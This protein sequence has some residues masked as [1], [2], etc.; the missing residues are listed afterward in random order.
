M[1]QLLP[2]LALLLTTLSVH[3]A[4]S[5]YVDLVQR[6]TDLEYLATLPAPGNTCAQWSSYDR[7][8]QYDEATGKYLGWGAN[9]DGTG[10]IRLEGEQQV[11]AEMTGPGCIWRI[12]SAA[13]RAGHVRIY[14]DGAAE[15]AVDLPFSGYFDRQTEPF[16]YPSL[17][18]NTGSGQNNYVP[19]PYSKSCK[20]VADQDWGLYFQFVYQTFPAG[21]V[22]PTFKLALSAEEKAAL[23][24]AD[25]FLSNKLGTAPLVRPHVYIGPQQWTVRA[26]QT[27]RIDEIKGSG[28]I[29]DLHASLV[30]VPEA[31]VEKALREVA[32]Q[33]KWDG[34]T[35][36]SVWSPLGDFFGTGPG[37]N[38]YKSLP[39]GITDKEFYS[40]WYMP[41]SKSAAVELVNDGQTDRTVRLVVL[42][43]ALDQA[44][45][46]TLARF[47]AKWHRDIFNPEAP[48]RAPDWTMLKTEG[49]GRFVGVAL[50]VWNPRGGWWGEGDEKFFVDGEKFPST[51]GTGSEDY[52][53]YAWCNPALFANAYHNQTRNDGNNFNHAS[54]N[55]WHIADNVPFQTSFEAAIEKYQGNQRPTQYEAVAYW[56]LAPGGQDG[57]GPVPL[58]ERLDYYTQLQIKNADG[59]F[60][61]EAL[62]FLEGSA[63]AQEMDGFGQDKWSG[64]MQLWWTPGQPGGK[65]VLAIPVEKDG[66]YKLTTVLTKAID[67]GLVQL[68]LD[69]RKLGD[70][71]DLF[72]HGVIPTPILDLG[73]HDLTQGDHRL[74]VEMIGKHDA[75]QPGYMFGMDWIKLSEVR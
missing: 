53:G 6:L 31:E 8:S 70:P 32:L 67:Y 72:N 59:A 2:L 44:K 66:K 45:A 17:V 75:A 58:A 47:H 15:P 22:V 71:I 37:I 38:R 10:F 16:I 40:Y 34:E 55:R 69:D 23:Q 41:F 33:I 74:T 1:R 20:I 50:N 43:E 56:Y 26:G 21:T 11:L 48:D 57:Y 63:G 64:D 73:T 27:L 19:I 39:M 52:F 3:A 49:R 46:D 18:H 5:I 68:Y 30:D 42:N 54:V 36:P 61:A 51:I 9:G 65:I 28:A 35:E 12:W 25:D 13:P 60:E 4:T 24:K 14:L 7:A 62:K 29:T